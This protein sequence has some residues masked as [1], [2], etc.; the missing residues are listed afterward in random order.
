MTER[1]TWASVCF[2]LLTAACFL[3]LHCAFLHGQIV[4]LGEQC[5]SKDVVA[6][7]VAL[8]ERVMTINE[9]F[10]RASA[11]DKSAAHWKTLLMSP[12]LIKE[13]ADDDGKVRNRS[14]AGT[15]PGVRLVHAQAGDH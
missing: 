10:M 11:I 13:T 12:H 6:S 15:G 1:I 4:L 8:T 7:Q 5:T 2:V 14:Q 3:A 9:S